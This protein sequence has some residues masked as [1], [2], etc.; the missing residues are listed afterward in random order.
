M[1]TGLFVSEVLCASG[2]SAVAS[3]VVNADTLITALITLGVSIVTVLGGELVRF[4]TTYIQ[5]KRKKLEEDNNKEDN[6]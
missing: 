1:N 2:V 3:T 4:L 5:N 6:K